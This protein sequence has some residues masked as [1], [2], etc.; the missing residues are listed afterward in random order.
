MPFNF[1]VNL[2]RENLIDVNLANQ[3][4]LEYKKFIVLGVLF[5]D[6]TN[7]PSEQVDQVWHLH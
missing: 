3:W 4:L 5:P 6:K 1:L 2:M 7:T